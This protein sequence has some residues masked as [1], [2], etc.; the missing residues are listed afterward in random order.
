MN[1][2]NKKIIKIIH[3]DK[4]EKV[5]LYKNLFYFSTIHTS[6]ELLLI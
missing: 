5:L 1:Y 6:L 4:S 3:I 2:I